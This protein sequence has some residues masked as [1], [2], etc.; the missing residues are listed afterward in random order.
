MVGTIHYDEE[1]VNFLFDKEDFPKIEERPWH[2]TLGKYVSTRIDKKDVHLHNFLNE[3][4]PSTKCVDHINR[5]GFDNRREN[6]RL[7]TNS[8]QNIYQARK[9]RTV[10]LPENCGIK[11]ADIPKHIWY[12]QPNGQHGDRFAIEFKT[13]NICWKSTSCKKITLQE[14]LQ[15]A[16]AKLELFYLE[17]KYL[18]PK[19]EE[20]KV[21]ALT[22]SYNAIMKIY[23]EQLSKS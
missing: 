19:V 4:K 23:S 17:Y 12:I 10:I 9:E 13:E 6:L 18:D 3:N 16:K 5:N 14:K 21:R 7:L 8:Q 20:A 1:D 2:V 15:E 11:H 22:S